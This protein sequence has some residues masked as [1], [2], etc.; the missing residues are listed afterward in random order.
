MSKAALDQLTRC[1]SIDL[2]KDGIRVN[3][4]NPGKSMYLIYLALDAI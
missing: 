1:A 3:A 4:V 2:A